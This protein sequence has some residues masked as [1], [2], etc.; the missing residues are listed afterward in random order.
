MEMPVLCLFKCYASLKKN[1][2]FLS[3]NKKLIVIELPLPVAP[4]HNVRTHTH[5]HRY[6]RHT[7]LVT[8]TEIRLYLSFPIYL[9][10]KENVFDSKS[11]E[12]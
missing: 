11:M 10:L 3:I 4:L 8:S 1:L 9:K 12:K 6:I 5:T 7:I 2:Y